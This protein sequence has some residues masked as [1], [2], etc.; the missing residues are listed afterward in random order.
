[1]LG[2]VWWN[3]AGF[4]VPPKLMDRGQEILSGVSPPY[5]NCDVALDP[6]Q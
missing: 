2:L 5:G 6:A 3:W 4:S 1:M